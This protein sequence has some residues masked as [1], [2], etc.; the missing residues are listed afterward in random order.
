MPFLGAHMS[1]AGGFHT[2]VDRAVAAGCDTVQ[3]FVQ[4]PRQ[5]ARAAEAEGQPGTVA[6]AAAERFRTAVEAA[7]LTAPCAHA[8]YLINLASPNET[9]WAKSIEAFAVELAR[10][11]QLGLAGLVVHPGTATGID[12]DAALDNVV[13]ALNA[14]L[15]RSATERIEI[16]LETTAGQGASLGHRFE[17]LA[18]LID[19]AERPERLGVCLDT[20]HVFAAGYPLIAPKEFA[21]TVAAFDEV[22]GL[23]RLRALHLN[24]SKKPLGSRVDRHEHIGDG[25]LGLEPFR[26]LLNDKRFAKLPMYLETAK[27]TLDGRDLDVVNLERLRGLIRRRGDAARPR[28]PRKR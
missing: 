4:P 10:S 21:A 6:P 7:G 15:D 14:A 3:L 1:A 2:A 12:E 28:S 19:R 11:E 20:C 8:S 24:D 13:R 16:W 23:S 26:H 22:V 18:A 9:L 25:C 27:G 5:W 17:H